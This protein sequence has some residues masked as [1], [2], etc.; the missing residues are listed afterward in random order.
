MQVVRFA[1]I[2]T[3]E[4]LIYVYQFRRAASPRKRA[5]CEKYWQSNK[6]IPWRDRKTHQGSASFRAATAALCISLSRLREL[7]SIFHRNYDGRVY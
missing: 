4:M 2:V 3:R 7:N 5:N 1:R 6:R